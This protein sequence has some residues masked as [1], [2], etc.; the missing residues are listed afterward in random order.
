MEWNA[1][2]HADMLLCKNYLALD[3]RYTYDQSA[4]YQEYMFVPRYYKSCKEVCNE[5]EV[6]WPLPSCPNDKS[7]IGYRSMNN[8]GLR[9]D[10]PDALLME[11]EVCTKDDVAKG[12]ARCCRK[13][14][15]TFNNLSKRKSSS[16]YW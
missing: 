10:A 14:Y 15:Q 1:S 6:L 4:S 12:D 16:V 7:I 11:R 3:K 2:E 9:R 8:S 5:N 13:E